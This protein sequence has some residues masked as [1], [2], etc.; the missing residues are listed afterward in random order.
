MLNF[1]YASFYKIYSLLY[2]KQLRV[3]VIGYVEVI[4][5]FTLGHLA[6]KPVFSKHHF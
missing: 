5:S 3:T 4:G 6:L 1:F 2:V